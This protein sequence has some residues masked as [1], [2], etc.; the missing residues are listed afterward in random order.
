[1]TICCKCGVAKDADQFYPIAKRLCKPCYIQRAGERARE[2]QARDPARYSA[3]KVKSVVAWQKRH[4]EKWA[5]INRR[6]QRTWREKNTG[7]ARAQSKAHK[8]AKRKAMPSWADG[9]AIVEVYARAAELQRVTGVRMS[10]DHIIPLRGKDVCGL[11]VHN[12]L[13][14]MPLR[15]NQSKGNRF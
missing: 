9:P 3:Q 10:V 8:L 14:I 13:E 1:M 2:R 4:P 15:E 12:N 11:H 7:A 5:E 6:N